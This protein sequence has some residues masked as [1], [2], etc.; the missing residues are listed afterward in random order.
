MLN[1]G[2]LFL[3]GW[4][5]QSFWPDGLYTAPSDD[6][7]LFD[8]QALLSFG[9][10]TVRLH[11]KVNPERWY[12]HADRLGVVVLQDAVQKYGG[13]TAGTVPLFMED[14]TRMVAGR[15]NHPCIV[16]WELFNEMD[17]WQVFNVSAAVEL[18]QLLDPSRLLDT[19]SGGT[20]NDYQLADVNDLHTYPYPG[21]PKP[22]ATQYGMLGEYGGLGAY[23][24]GHEWV[25]A[26]CQSYLAMNSTTA[27]AD[28][29]VQMAASILG[30]GADIS[31]TIYTQIADV[32]RECDGFLNYDRTPKWSSADTQRVI[33]ANQALIRE[34]N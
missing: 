10:N 26:Q 19:D 9:F 3:N 27:F 22:S 18:M 11:Q 12:Y 28:L 29:Y 8:L 16:Q 4:L 13:A 15:A 32:E 25:P 30:N 14:L 23:V 33:A 6:A 24:P 21:D 7:L 1:G 20:A 5:D 34:I 2:F 17:C 31:A